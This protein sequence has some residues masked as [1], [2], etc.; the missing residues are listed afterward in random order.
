M[1]IDERLRDD[2]RAHLEGLKAVHDITEKSMFG[3]IGFMWRG[4]LLCGVTGEELLVRV[5]KKDG[6]S[7]LGEDGAH[8]MV[9]GG[10]SSQG[11]ILVPMPPERRDDLLSRWVERAVSFA[12]SLPAKQ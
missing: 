4:N 6:A 12:S 3:G 8:P 11:W 2:L 1:A 7:F 5:D 9:M 10:R